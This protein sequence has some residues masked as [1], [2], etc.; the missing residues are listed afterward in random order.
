MNGKYSIRPSFTNRT[1]PRNRTSKKRREECREDAAKRCYP[2]GNTLGRPAKS[3]LGSRPGGDNATHC[4]GA[5]VEVQGRNFEVQLKF[6][7]IVETNGGNNPSNQKV[8]TTTTR[9][10]FKRLNDHE[11]IFAFLLR[12]L[13]SLPRVFKTCGT[14]RNKWCQEECVEG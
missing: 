1:K 5:L 4:R 14:H 6:K 7:H 10:E 9:K 8:P 13:C 2:L 12:V 11:N 3:P